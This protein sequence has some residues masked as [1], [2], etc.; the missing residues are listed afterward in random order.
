MREAASR[1]QGTG[2]GEQGP[3]IGGGRIAVCAVEGC[4]AWAQRGEY[5]RR[6]AEEIEAL[7]SGRR[8]REAR[9]LR[10]LL[11]EEELRERF[12]RACRFVA[13]WLWA[14]ELIFVG[15]VMLY[16]GWQFGAMFVMWM[17]GQ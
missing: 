17:V 15:A 12:R 16:L 14:P 7:E 10:R 5:C 3:R 2:I 4:R 11:R 1:E 9:E 13:K 6:C 8:D